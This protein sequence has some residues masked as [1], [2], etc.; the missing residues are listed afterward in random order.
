MK[1]VQIRNKAAPS[2][3]IPDVSIQ[4]SR[5]ISNQPG[6][7]AVYIA[8]RISSGRTIKIIPINYNTRNRA[9]V[10]HIAISSSLNLAR[11]M[12]KLSKRR[13]RVVWRDMNIS[14]TLNIPLN[15]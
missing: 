10:Q 8:S 13:C 7:H 3:L 1:L 14:G 2:E 9:T 11:C 5:L 4:T 12:S 15:I 6:A